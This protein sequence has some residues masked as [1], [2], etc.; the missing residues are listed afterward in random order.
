MYYE[1]SSCPSSHCSYFVLSEQNG[2]TD[3]K[4]LDKGEKMKC[5][6]I[7]DGDTCTGKA[8]LNCEWH[9][10]IY[11]C[12]DKGVAIPCVEF[13]FNGEATCPDYCKYQETSY[14]D[15]ECL[16]KTATVACEDYVESTACDGTRCQWFELD[17]SY[18]MCTAK[19]RGLDCTMLMNRE[20]KE[21]GT[22]QW[23][24]DSGGQD[25]GVCTDCPTSEC[26]ESA[27]DDG[28][29]GPGPEDDDGSAACSTFKG[30]DVYRCPERCTLRFPGEDGSGDICVM[31]GGGDADPTCIQKQCSDSSWDSE[32]CTSQGSKCVWVEA[33]SIC[34]TK[35]GK[36]PCSM[37]FDQ[38]S[39]PTALCS[40]VAESSDDDQEDFGRC[41]QEGEVMPCSDVWN[42]DDCSKKQTTCKWFDA[43][44]RC[45]DKDFDPDC[46]CY[47]GFGPEL[48]PVTAGKCVLQNGVCSSKGETLSCNQIPFAASCANSGHCAW[49]QADH[50]CTGCVNDVCPAQQPC[51]TYTDEYTCPES[52]CE[53]IMDNFEANQDGTCGDKKCDSMQ[54]VEC[55]GAAACE[56]HATA[57]PEGIC[58][59]KGLD[60]PCNQYWE[61][62]PCKTAAVGCTW[63]QD[64]FHCLESGEVEPCS[65]YESD[66]CPADR[67]I[68][69]AETT[70]DPSSCQ[71]NPAKFTHTPDKL[72]GKGD[73]SGNEDESKCTAAQFSDIRT[74]LEEAQDEC[75]VI[76]RH[77]GRRTA[78]LQV[79]CLA[80][81]LDQSPSPT[82]I[83]KACPC[84]WKYA[85]SVDPYSTAW[86][87][88]AC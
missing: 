83:A 60:V 2:W 59:P 6:W 41:L 37:A 53:F 87:K 25:Y 57:P 9:D 77:R 85:G 4:C 22:C 17:A 80:Y 61:E 54:S 13:R 84:I 56:W 16:N 73:G 19:G 34:Y 43:L 50:M 3:G 70:M 65:T 74:K 46:T 33:S 1:Q 10:D 52:H 76:H 55:D 24:A 49:N 26:K 12:W 67:C 82:T 75:G 20:C 29:V 63:D 5:E 28:G 86:M 64:N 45:V 62:N 35:G 32:G 72:P 78:D 36:Y 11:K 81:F 7:Y 18:G 58:F 15:G 31:E 38:T 27:D 21:A 40:W 66:T 42:E 69:M 68:A 47:N 14:M 30:D 71:I 88:V 48:C 23:T 79:E 44:E 39:C 51:A 8:E